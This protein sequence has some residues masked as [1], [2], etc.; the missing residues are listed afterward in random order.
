MLLVIAPPRPAEPDPRSPPVPTLSRDGDVFLLDLG[1]DENRFNPDWL[2]SVGAAL[3]EVE[4]APAPRALVTTA[5][6]KFWSN[7]LDLAWMGEHADELGEFVPDVHELLAR[8]LA[9]WPPCATARQ[10]AH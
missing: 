2:A 8:V 5:T 6:G 7:G 10:A 9:L 1:S 4:A 3:D